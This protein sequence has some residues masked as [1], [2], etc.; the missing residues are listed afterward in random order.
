MGS[1]NILQVIVINYPVLRI[2]P[3]RVCDIS[4]GA[5]ATIINFVGVPA[6]EVERTLRAGELWD[7]AATSKV[8]ASV[9]GEKAAKA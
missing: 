3:P 8:L 7:A 5:A 6:D 2:R 4:P 9:G 1:G